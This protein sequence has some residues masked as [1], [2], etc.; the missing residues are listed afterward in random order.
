MPLGELKRTFSTAL[1][2]ISHVAWAAGFCGFGS[3]IV[4]K[5]QRLAIVVRI[6]A[7]KIMIDAHG[8]TQMHVFMPA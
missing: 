8:L 7:I 3:S 2:H 5:T 4:H 6:A 1:A